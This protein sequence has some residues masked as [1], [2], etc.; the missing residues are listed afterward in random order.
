VGGDIKQ[1]KKKKKA[2]VHSLESYKLPT[3]PPIVDLVG[4]VSELMEEVKN[5]TG[6]TVF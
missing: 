6:R 3:S 4:N 2:P 1:G 5:E